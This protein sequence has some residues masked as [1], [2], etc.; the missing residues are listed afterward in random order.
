MTPGKKASS[1]V[2]ADVIAEKIANP[3]AS[4]RDLAKGK[5]VSHETVRK[6]LDEEA[7]DLLT[8]SDKKHS[9]LETNL[10]IID[11]ATK[12][13]EKAMQT[14]TPKKILEAKQM[15]DIVETAFKQN[16]LL[17]GESTSNESIKITWSV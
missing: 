14:M 3:D 2:I 8:S 5:D 6:I 1:K 17:Q 15:Q 9:L 7:P 12:K 16:Q 13:I 11:T 10:N 4:L